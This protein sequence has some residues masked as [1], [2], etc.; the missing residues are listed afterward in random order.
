M[1]SVIELM[2][3]VYRRLRLPV[4]F[5]G[6]HMRQPHYRKVVKRLQKADKPYRFGAY[7]MF[8]ST[9]GADRLVQK[10]LDN[11]EKWSV[12]IVVIPD[13]SRG[14]KHMVEAYKETKAFFVN[15]Y[16]ESYVKDGYD[17]Q[18]H[19]A[20]DHSDDF[21]FIYCAN[22]YDRMVAKCHKIRY[23][24]KRNCLPFHISYGYD[25]SQIYTLRRLQS[26]E[27]NYVWKYFTDTRYLHENLCAHHLIKGKNFELM[28]YAKMDSFI[29]DKTS[30]ERKRILIS[31][32]HSVDF[33]EL[34][35]SNFME[36]YDLIPELPTIFP[37]YDFVFRPHPLLFSRLV[38]LGL[39]N[40]DNV[41][42]YIKKITDNG[43]EYSVGGDY[44]D[45]FNKCDAIV[46]DCGS[47]TVEW[48]YSGKPGCFIR[49][50]SLKDE[51]L[52]PLMLKAL[53]EYEIVTSKDEILSFIRDLDFSKDYEVADW[54]KKDVMLEY[55]NVS[56]K[57]Y[58]FLTSCG[59]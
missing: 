53:E 56:D 4:N 21:D 45:V 33:P 37:E 41:K 11:P 26:K 47:F 17:F 55:P 44:F 3:I 40:E 12:S 27:L 54:V 38:L 5:L 59:T 14:E 50:S 13:I 7:V 18:A 15:K 43:I 30:N 58:E 6:A 19:R 48:L 28:G 49:N 46:N 24:S 51:L 32:H 23:L 20:I 1:K 8:D 16:G 31:I 22:P 52:T 35:L 29:F 10:M 39:W 9:F 36:I 25:V 2:K 57:I 34:P 42:D